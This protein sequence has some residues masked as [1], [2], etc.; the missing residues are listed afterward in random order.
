V[1]VTKMKLKQGWATISAED[2]IENFIATGGRIY[3]TLKSLTKTFTL[4]NTKWR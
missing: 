4:A 3:Y 2:H 1:H